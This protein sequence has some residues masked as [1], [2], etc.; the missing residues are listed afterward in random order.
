[1]PT[2]LVFKNSQVTDTVKGADA[3]ALRT[4]VKRAAAEAARGPAKTSAAFQ[5]KGH[6]LGNNSASTGSSSSSMPSFDI[7]GITSAL[8]GPGFLSTVIR[9]LGLYVTSLLSFDSMAAAERSPFAVQDTRK[10]Q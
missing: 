5:S 6:V 8:N 7:S 1:M 2:F 3:N 10:R 4:V 9:F